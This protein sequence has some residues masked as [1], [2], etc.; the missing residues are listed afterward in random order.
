MKIPIRDELR[1]LLREVRAWTPI[2]RAMEEGIGREEA[3]YIDSLAAVRE[4]V[5]ILHGEF[6]AAIISAT[7]ER[8]N[9]R[10]A[11]ERARGFL[12]DAE[13]LVN[14]ESQG[15]AGEESEDFSLSGMPGESGPPGQ[16]NGPAAE[17][18]F[19]RSRRLRHT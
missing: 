18:L 15:M 11:E 12:R 10:R 1:E 7:A 9:A 14:A 13:E 4:E 17:D 2:L 16:G 19:E 8:K 5:A 6:E 3:S